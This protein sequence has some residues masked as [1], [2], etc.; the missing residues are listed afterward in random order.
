MVHY[1][2]GVIRT[3]LASFSK[4]GIIKN[5]IALLIKKVNWPYGQFTFNKALKIINELLFRQDQ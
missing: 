2:R 1:E 5:L 4:D 3:L